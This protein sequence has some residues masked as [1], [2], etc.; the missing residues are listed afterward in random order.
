MKK[1]ARGAKRGVTWASVRR[2]LLDLPGVAEGTSYGMP[3]FLL[4]GKFFS[5]FNEKEQGLVVHADVPLRDTLLASRSGVYFTTDH[6][7]N[8]PYVL[9]RL[10]RVPHAELAALLENAFRAR[11][12][13][14]RIAEYDGDT[15]AT[16]KK[17]P[18]SRVQRRTTATR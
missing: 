9:V 2:M 12:K 15:A 6:Y 3:A 14:R 18:A 16:K 1:A 11:A 5:R 10:E 13:K 7:R 4:D 17:R 8:Y